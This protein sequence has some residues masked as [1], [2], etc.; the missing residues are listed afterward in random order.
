MPSGSIAA[1]IPSR[2][3]S[4]PS[5]SAYS[6]VA[7]CAMLIV[8]PLAS[9]SSMKPPVKRSR[10]HASATRAG[11]FTARRETASR[12]RQCAPVDPRAHV[13]VGRQEA[14][15]DE[16]A[17]EIVERG[18]RRFV[19]IRAQPPVHVRTVREP[20]PVMARSRLAAEIA[21]HVLLVLA[22]QPSTSVTRARKRLTMSGC[23]SSVDA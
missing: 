9:A 16:E 3:L 4:T 15:F 20:Q 2:A 8:V 23:R 13:E 19:E 17:L 5:A 10:R 7:S 12:C 11:A 6:V 18:D 1:M 14:P 22:R 21:E